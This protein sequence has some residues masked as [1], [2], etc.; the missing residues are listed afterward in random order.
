LNFCS[1]YRSYIG[2]AY[3]ITRATW[4][5]IRWE[6][7]PPD[8]EQHQ[9]G[10]LKDK[11]GVSLQ[12]VPDALTAMWIGAHSAASLSTFAAMLQMKKIDISLLETATRMP[13]P[14]IVAVARRL[15]VCTAP[16]VKH[17]ALPLDKMHSTFRGGK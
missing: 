8:G 14:C 7:L 5:S 16:R 15:R 1:G 12:W 13:D 2:H 11:F 9:C 3:F 17:R 6:K 4:R 10:W